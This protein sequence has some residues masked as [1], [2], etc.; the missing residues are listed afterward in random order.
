[1][2]VCAGDVYITWVHFTIY[3]PVPDRNVSPQHLTVCDLSSLTALNFSTPREPL[4]QTIHSGCLLWKCTVC[5][6]CLV[7]TLNCMC[8]LT[9]LHRKT[10]Q[11]IT[12]KYPQALLT[13]SSSYFLQQSRTSIFPFKY[14]RS[15]HNTDFP[16]YYYLAF[17]F[18]VSLLIITF[19]WHHEAKLFSCRVPKLTGFLIYYII[20]TLPR[21]LLRACGNLPTKAESPT[22]CDIWISWWKATWICMMLKTSE[23]ASQ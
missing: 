21:L 4:N 17:S 22:R 16:A 19:L 18:S 12:Q 20:V 10:L 13:T 14:N 23:T 2:S 11:N 1:M 9:L 8:P 6:D 3:K 15:I 7:V 5:S